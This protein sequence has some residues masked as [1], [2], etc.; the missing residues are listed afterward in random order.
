MI[1]LVLIESKENPK[2][3]ARFSIAFAW[4]SSSESDISVKALIEGRH[5]ASFVGDDL[6]IL[7]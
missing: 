7:G 3:F 1:D 2:A 4:R 6:G 5:Y